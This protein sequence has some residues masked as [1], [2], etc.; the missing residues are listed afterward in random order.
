MGGSKS[1]LLAQKQAVPYV[2]YE[3]YYCYIPQK[4]YGGERRI[5]KVIGYMEV[6][7]ENRIFESIMMPLYPGR[8]RVRLEWGVQ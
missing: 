4:V 6:Q 1:P 2:P 8:C 5:G 3:I 7:G